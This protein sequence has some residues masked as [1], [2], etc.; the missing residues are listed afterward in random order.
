MRNISDMQ[1]AVES[2]KMIK[3]YFSDPKG[4]EEISNEWQNKW[5]RDNTNG[6]EFCHKFERL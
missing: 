5:T 6:I 2:N 3:F 1:I 4:C